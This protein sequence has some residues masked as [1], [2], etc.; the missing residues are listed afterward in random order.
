MPSKHEAGRTAPLLD[1]HEI[2][3][4]GGC[5]AFEGLRRKKRVAEPP[6]GLF[7]DHNAA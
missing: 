5:L 4:V 2:H 7:A 6:D 1:R 3:R